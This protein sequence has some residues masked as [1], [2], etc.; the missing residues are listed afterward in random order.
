MDKK[1][2]RRKSDSTFPDEFMV[3]VN[4]Y[5][6]SIGKAAFVQIMYPALKS[7]PNATVEE[8]AAKYPAFE[9]FKSKSMR[10]KMSR[11]IFEE[12][13][14]YEALNVIK[15]SKLVPKTIKDEAQKL[16][17]EYKD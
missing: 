9:K 16:I 8:I 6:K 3:D 10:L 11:L 12:G 15:F 17:D 14:V 13:S 1:T 2:S 5:L 7:N 4:K